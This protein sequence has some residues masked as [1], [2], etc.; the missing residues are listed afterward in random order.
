MVERRNLKWQG[1]RK[2]NKDVL[3]TVDLDGKQVAYTATALQDLK[4]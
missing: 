3:T 1:G 2:A 4:P